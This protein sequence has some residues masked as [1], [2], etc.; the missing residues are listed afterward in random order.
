[1]LAARAAHDGVRLRRA[2]SAEPV[3]AGWRTHPAGTV[4][5]VRLDLV[6]RPDRHDICR[7]IGA[8]SIHLA[9]GLRQAGYERSACLD[10]GIELWVRD[11]PASIR[12]RLAGFSV[13][14]GGR[15]RQR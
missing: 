8:P 1:V 7:A 12:A 14:D 3:P 5:G 15:V 9:A 2:D 13:L 4:D 10:G 6:Y 11:R